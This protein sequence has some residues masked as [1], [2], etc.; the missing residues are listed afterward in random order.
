MVWV[1]PPADAAAAALD[2]LIIPG[3]ATDASAALP[4]TM[5]EFLRKVRRSTDRPPNSMGA[6]GFWSP[7]SGFVLALFISFIAV[8][9]LIWKT[10]SHA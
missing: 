3:V 4:A 6:T 9:L 7:P 2:F 1:S 8:L 5:P 10:V